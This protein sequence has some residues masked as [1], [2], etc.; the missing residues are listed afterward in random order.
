MHSLLHPALRRRN[1]VAETQPFCCRQTYL[2]GR[3][4]GLIIDHSMQVKNM[5]SL[6]EI[7]SES[8]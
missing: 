7:Y 1:L 3:I 2:H 8:V 4:M 5:P 6:I